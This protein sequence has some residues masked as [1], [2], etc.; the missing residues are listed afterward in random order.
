MSVVNNLCLLIEQC[1]NIGVNV[2][3]TMC[4]HSVLMVRPAHELPVPCHNNLALAPQS[5]FS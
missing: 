1:K 2:T 3:A 5:P 4:Q